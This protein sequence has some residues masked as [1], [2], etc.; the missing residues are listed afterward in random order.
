MYSSDLPWWL[1][2]MCPQGY[3]GRAWVQQRAAHFNFPPHLND[4]QSGHFLYTMLADED[5]LSGNLLLGNEMLR[6]YQNPQLPNLIASADRAS[7]YAVLAASGN[8]QGSSAQVSSQ[9]SPL[10]PRLMMARGTSSSNSAN[11]Q[12]A[13]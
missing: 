3:L 9:N 4:W 6:R 2:D 11:C 10:T 1:Y 12:T 7:A 13:P 8:A 5:G